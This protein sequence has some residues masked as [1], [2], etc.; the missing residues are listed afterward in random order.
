MIAT[1]ELRRDVL[2]VLQTYFDAI[3]ARD[4]S[5]VLPLF[6]DDPDLV[7]FGSGA[8]ER[9]VG[10]AGLALQTERDWS[11]SDSMSLAITWSSVSSAGQVAWASTELTVSVRADGVELSLPARFSVVLEQ[12]G[13]RWLIVQGHF[14]LPASEQSEGESFPI[15]G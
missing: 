4:L 5:A 6:A 11:Q 3:A 13:D 7:L 2:A 9:R 15:H 12:R 1:P 14:S 10:R 8:D